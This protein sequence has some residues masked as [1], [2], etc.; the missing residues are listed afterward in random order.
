MDLDAL[1][2]RRTGSSDL[3]SRHE[4]HVTPLSCRCAIRLCS[5][6]CEHALLRFDPCIGS[7]SAMT[8]RVNYAK[9]CIPFAVL[10]MILGRQHRRVES[11]NT[12]G[13]VGEGRTSRGLLGVSQAT[14]DLTN[15]G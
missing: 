2:I 15:S 10:S 4:T 13:S 14:G 9:H 3:G 8:I 7:N 11:V 12:S 1:V 5:A 6:K